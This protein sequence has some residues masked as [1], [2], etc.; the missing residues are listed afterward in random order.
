LYLF[1]FALVGLYWGGTR[2]IIWLYQISLNANVLAIMAGLLQGLVLV[3]CL[4]RHYHVRV[5]LLT[6][7]YVFILM[8]PFLAQVVAMTG[9]IDMIFDYRQRFSARNQK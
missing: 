6:V 1:G 2:E 5:V 3:H 4:M 9:L 7:C 8:N